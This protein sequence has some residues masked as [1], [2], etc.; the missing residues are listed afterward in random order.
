MIEG[1]RIVLRFKGV[2][3]YDDPEAAP[4]EDLELLMASPFGDLVLTW[5]PGGDLSWRLQGKGE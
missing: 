5:T 1:D 3:N 4:T 2:A